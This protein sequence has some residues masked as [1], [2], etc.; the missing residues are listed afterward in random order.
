ME[1]DKCGKTIVCL[2]IQTMDDIN[3]SFAFH[4][5]PHS[6]VSHWALIDFSLFDVIPA[7]TVTALVADSL[8]RI[9]FPFSVFFRKS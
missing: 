9:C 2:L 3:N 7:V 8:P 1:Y 5:F 6:I 4:Q